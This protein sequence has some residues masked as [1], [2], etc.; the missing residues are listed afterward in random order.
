MKG[1]NLRPSLSR[2]G[3]LKAGI[4][5]AGGLILGVKIS[6]CGG[7]APLP[8]EASFVSLGRDPLP[9]L[10][11]FLGA[12]VRIAPDSTVTLRVNSSEMGQGVF[13][14]LPMLI[15]EELKVPWEKVRAEMAP[16]HVRYRRSTE[17]GPESQLTAESQSI[18]QQYWPL[19]QAGAAAREMLR[20]AAAAKLGVPLGE[21][22]ARDGILSH[23]PSGKSLSYGEVAVAAGALD[24]PEDAPLTADAALRLLGKATPRLDVPAKARGE[25]IFGID[26][27]IPGMAIAVVR[28]PPVFGARVASVD[29]TKAK[30]MAGVLKVVTLFDG[31]EGVGVIAERF[32]QAKAAAEA[33]EI[34]YEGGDTSLSSESIEAQLREALASPKVSQTIGEGADGLKGEGQRIE[35]EYVLPFL[36]HQTLEPQNC[37]AHVQADRVDVWAP[38]Q[39]QQGAQK[40]ASELTGL[41]LEACYI[42]TTFLGGG[43]GRRAEMDFIRQAV[44]LSKAASRPVQVRW[45]R[46]EDTTQD[47]YRPFFVA[48]LEGRV[49][50]D[51]ALKAWRH[52]NAGQNILTRFMPKVAITA[53]RG[54]SPVIGPTVDVI[55]QQGALDL[56]Y[57]IPHQEIAFAKVDLPIPVGFWRSVGHSVNGFVV[58]SFVDELAAAAKVD[59]ADFRRGLLEDKPRHLA[60]LERAL[61][62][63][64]Y[65]QAPLGRAQGVAFHES[66]GSI[67]CQVAEIEV[68]SEGEVKVHRVVSVVDCG[69][70]VNPDIVSAQIEG[71]MALGLSAAIGEIVDIE[72]GA[73]KQRNFDGYPILT[74]AQCP[75]SDVYI[76]ESKEEP[77]GIGEPGVPPI[78]A[79]LCNAL[80]QGTGR[81]IRR[82][83]LSRQGIQ[84]I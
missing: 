52:V 48:K 60:V 36:A 57:A 15:A 7:V 73:V 54:L 82:L 35:A 16:A 40:M 66:F 45:T 84:V 78:A 47:Y 23:G 32:W 1:E 25:A 29:D 77:G 34:T 62:E 39:G 38:T 30:A 71:G 18:R 41:P 14:A 69:R 51:G 68:V 12:W 4:V 67:V 49:A 58:E 44:A 22:E 9:D 50:E 65:G 75:E 76:I 2:R 46:E 79:A 24:I 72:G 74:M 5:G 8:T 3:F 56:P 42:H 55:A 61:K 59:P 13:T 37:T 81:R 27:D 26:V 10:D 80:F 28:R 19:R 33:L 17:W 53:L 6:G 21:I 64:G 83:P 43:F 20:Q 31:E 11:T 70:V 63:S